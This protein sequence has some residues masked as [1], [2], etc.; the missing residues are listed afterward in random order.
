MNREITLQSTAP[1]PQSEIRNPKSKG[2][3]GRLGPAH[4]NIEVTNDCNLRCIMCPGRRMPRPIGYMG[5]ALYR[6]ICDEAVRIGTKS[7]LLYLSGE[8]LL[9]PELPEMVKYAK[10]AE[11]GFVG[12]STNATLLTGEKA[13]Q[14]LESKID[15]MTISLDGVNKAT[16]ESLRIGAPHYHKNNRN[17][18]GSHHQFT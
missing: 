10:E 18:A 7:F 11:I 14:L 12:L 2:P 16:Y 13:R 17:H 3:P 8:P 9:H 6:K 1:N 15:R 4:I 5:M